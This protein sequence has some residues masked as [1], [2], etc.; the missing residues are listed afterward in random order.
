MALAAESVRNATQLPRDGSALT[1]AVMREKVLYPTTTI[2][3]QLVALRLHPTS[4]STN[5]V[6]SCWQ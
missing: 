2:V 1:A 5:F 4:A 6:I 3:A